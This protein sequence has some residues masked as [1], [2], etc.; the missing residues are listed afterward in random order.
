MCPGAPITFEEFKKL[1]GV[2]REKMVHESSGDL[3]EKLQ[4]WNYRIQKGET[5]WQMMQ[6]ERLIHKKG[7]NGLLRL[8]SMQGTFEQECFSKLMS[9]DANSGVSHKDLIV[10]YQS[11]SKEMD[12]DG[13]V[14]AENRLLFASLIPSPEASALAKKADIIQ[15]GW[16]NRYKLDKVTR[17]GIKTLNAQ[18]DEIVGEAKKLPRVTPE[19]LQAEIDALPE[20]DPHK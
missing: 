18:V 20:E 7:I 8:I 14:Y 3:S 13:T 12:R 16:Q 5:A 9:P 4:R 6:L 19:Q 17:E 10:K 1:S 2:D 15:T 11:L